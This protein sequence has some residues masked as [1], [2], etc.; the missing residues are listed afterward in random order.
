MTLA[1]NWVD[2]IGMFVNAAYLNQLGTE[3]NASIYARTQ[4]GTRS[5]M[6]AAAA[7]NSGATYFCTD[8]DA[9]YESNGSTWIKIRAVGFGGSLS[10]PP[11][12]GWTA[13][14]L[15]S[16]ASFAQ[17]ADSMLFTVPSVGSGGN[18]QYEYIAYPGTPFTLTALID[19]S[20][21]PAAGSWAHAG[22]TVSDGTK[23][24]T[25][26]PG[27]GIAS[28]GSANPSLKF[29]SAIKFATTSTFSSTLG[30]TDLAKFTG[31]PKWLRL[32]DNG[33]NL[34]WFCSINGA[35]WFQIGASESRTAYL[36]TPTRL[37]VGATNFSGK[38]MLGRVRSW[39]IT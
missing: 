17:D 28:D 31:F 8:C 9:I 29:V 20:I 4:Y 1:T 11:F 30:Y 32:V 13:V 14:N 23:L 22:I 21:D 2:N 3:H 35:E 38:T 34:S 18:Y 26:G 39:K 37:A 24:M 10:D 15:Q 19:V 25:F 16:G 5:A 12:S 7:S 6:P 33:T 27:V 36:S